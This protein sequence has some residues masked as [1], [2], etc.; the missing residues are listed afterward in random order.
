MRLLFLVVLLFMGCDR[1]AVVQHNDA[2][3]KCPKQKRLFNEE[4]LKVGDLVCKEGTPTHCGTITAIKDDNASVQGFS[5]RDNFTAKLSELTLME[6][7]CE[8]GKAISEVRKCKCEYCTCTKD[9]KCDDI[10][11]PANAVSTTG[12]APLKTQGTGR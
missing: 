11:C 8:C 10:T 12:S 1:P 2:E 6:R 4:V 7:K 3:C 5:R 9:S